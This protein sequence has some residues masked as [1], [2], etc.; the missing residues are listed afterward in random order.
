VATRMTGWRR[1]T[2]A[3]RPRL[4]SLIGEQLK[5]RAASAE[6]PIDIVIAG[7]GDTGI[8]ATAAHAACLAGD[9][10]LAR[11]RFTVL[12]LCPTPTILCEEFGS[13]HGL[14]VK[15][16]A[17]DITKGSGST[18]ADFTIMHGVLRF[19]PR[20][21]HEAALRRL[22]EGLKPGGRIILSN[23]LHAAVTVS[24]PRGFASGNAL[25]QMI[26]DGSIESPEPVAEFTARIKRY[27]PVNRIKPE[28]E[29]ASAEA[30]RS[31]FEGAGLRVLRLDAFEEESR[32]SQAE[33]RQ[34]GRVHAVLGA[35]GQ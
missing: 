29:I 27:I 20:E 19:I 22:G 18:A 11:C 33:I 34:L 10:I 6:G 25:L 3:D 8:L 23:R 13:R 14:A 26:A 15:G 24:E 7:A 32:G 9:H 28:N 30:A 4:A 21:W 5:E 12:D 31:L 16:E 1:S 35:G 2:T 17:V